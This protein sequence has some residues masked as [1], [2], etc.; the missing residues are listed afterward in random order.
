[1]TVNY[2]ITGGTSIGGGVDYTLASGTATVTA[3]QLTTN[4]PLTIVQDMVNEPAETIIVTISNPIN[5]TLGG[6]TTHTY[7]INYNSIG[8]GISFEG[9]PL[10]S[11]VTEGSANNFYSIALTSQPNSD[12]TIN[13]NPDLQLTTSESSVDITDNDSAGVSVVQSGGSTTVSEAM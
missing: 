3:G 4:I 2:S 12:V 9:S 13:L 7:T 11:N 10:N 1:M 6:T 8:A 5:A